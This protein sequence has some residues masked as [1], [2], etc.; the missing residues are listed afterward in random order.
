MPGRRV[1]KARCLIWVE[2]KDCVPPHGLDM[3]WEHDRWKVA[4]LE[5]DFRNNGFDVSK[6]A[7]V[8]YILDG[9]IQLLSGTHRHLA[10]QRAGIQLPVT[11]WLRSDVQACWGTDLW[12]TVIADIPVEELLDFWIADDLRKSPYDEIELGIAYPKS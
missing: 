10:A 2:P 5:E 11:L 7:L 9:K 8:G 6:S 4:A 12:P 3:Q 1:V